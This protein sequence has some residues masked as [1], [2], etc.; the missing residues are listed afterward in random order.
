MKE[1]DV[2]DQ[3]TYVANTNMKYCRVGANESSKARRGAGGR[4]GGGRGA[5]YAR[6]RENRMLQKIPRAR[7]SDSV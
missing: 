3:M 6:G 4:G 5:D 7:K 1:S 2:Y